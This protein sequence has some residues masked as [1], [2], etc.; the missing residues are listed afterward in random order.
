MHKVLW[1]AGC[2]LSLGLGLNVASAN[3]V[4]VN[5][6]GHV[7]SVNDP[8]SPITVGEPVTAS[9][10]YDTSTAIQTYALCTPFLSMSVSVGGLTVQMQNNNNCMYLISIYSGSN[11]GQLVYDMFTPGQIGPAISVRFYDL[12]GHW[13][14]SSALPT[15]APPM[16]EAHGDI[17]VTPPNSSSF[18]VFNVQ[19][20]SATLAP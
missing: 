20:D 14:A 9:Y 8:S 3:V 19:V 6:T 2:A 5:L 18:N 7:T 1:F 17:S 16:S 10:S 15:N 4:T 12:S 11:F 13:P